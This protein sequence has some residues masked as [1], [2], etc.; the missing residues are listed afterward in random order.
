M[1]PLRLLLPIACLLAALTPIRADANVGGFP[2]AT[3]VTLRANYLTQYIRVDDTGGLIA[4]QPSW[5]GSLD[6]IFVEIGN[7]DGTVSFFSLKRLKYVTASSTTAQLMADASAIGPNQKFTI[8][9]SWYTGWSNG[10]TDKAI[11]SNALSTT[12]N[13]AGDTDGRIFS[14]WWDEASGWGNMSIMPISPPHQ[15][16]IGADV[17]EGK[18]ATDA[19]VVFTDTDGRAKPYLDIFKAHKYQWVRC[20]INVNPNGTI[21]LLQTTEYVRTVMAAAK[22]KNFKLLL[23]FHFSDWWADPGHQSTPAA[24]SG[25]D[26]ATLTTTLSNYVTTVMNTM[27]SANAWPDMIQ[28]GNETDSGMLWPLGGPWNGGSWDNYKQLHNAVYDAV[29]AAHGPNPMPKVMIHLAK[30]GD[31]GGTRWWIDTAL[32]YGFK[33]DVV[34]LSYYPQWHGT[35]P[36][37]KANLDNI[38]YRYPNLEIAIAETAYYF[39][40][41][42]YGYTSMPYPETPQGQYDFLAQLKRQVSLV[43]NANYVFYWGATW[44]EPDTWYTPI[45]PGAFDTANR[46]LFDSNGRALKAIDGLR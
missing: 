2:N 16:A 41:D 20:R 36:Q 44:C 34:G 40:P 7:T 10:G 9:P 3:F 39:A 11:F 26:I 4:D 37:L 6:E 17:S 46:G 12:W 42:A 25:Q 24:W 1:K 14:Q 15:P 5:D 19:G 35:I 31:V 33:F 30:G 18:G 32:S 21:G 29:A 43:K 13:I 27:A 22:Q 38:S 23:D 45:E 8:K 28:I